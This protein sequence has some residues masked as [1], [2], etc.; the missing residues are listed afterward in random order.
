MALS[1]KQRKQL[2]ALEPDEVL[3]YYKTAADQAKS[4]EEEKKDVSKILLAKLRGGGF[5][6]GMSYVR[7]DGVSASISTKWTET[8]DKAILAAHGVDPDIIKAA[9]KRTES[10]PFVTLHVPKAKG[11][12]EVGE[13]LGLDT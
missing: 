9:T 5:D 13:A 1:D 10:A 8:I 4:A 3:G 7:E 12:K 11:T 6:V 2:E